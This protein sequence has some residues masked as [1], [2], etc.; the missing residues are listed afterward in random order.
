LLRRLQEIRTT[1]DGDADQPRHL[2]VAN[3]PA[4]ISSAACTKTPEPR[5]RSTASK[6][7]A[8]GRKRLPTT[9]RSA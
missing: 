4:P 6:T 8:K 1:F 7:K 9:S 5:K 2:A 3:R